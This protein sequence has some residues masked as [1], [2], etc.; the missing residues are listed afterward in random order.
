MKADSIHCRLVDLPA[1]FL[2]P[3]PNESKANDMHLNSTA[4]DERTELPREVSIKASALLDTP[5]LNKGS[6]FPEDERRGLGLL[7]LLRSV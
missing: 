7:E 3:T 6:A 4:S 5:I 2:P 1:C